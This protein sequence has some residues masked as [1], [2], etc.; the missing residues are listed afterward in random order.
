MQG[1]DV[2]TKTLPWAL[3][4]LT[5]ICASTPGGGVVVFLDFDG[6]LSPIVERPETASIDD[7]TRKSLATLAKGATVAIVSGR[8]LDDVRQRVGLED[9]IYAGSHGF[10]I[11]GPTKKQFTYQ[12]GTDHLPQ[13]QKAEEI[14]SV[15]LSEI[16]GTILERKKFSIAV[17]Y[18]RTA[19]KDVD[20]VKDILNE[21]AVQFIGLRLT[22]GKKVLELQPDVDWH[23]G[24]AINYL[25]HEVLHIDPQHPSDYLYW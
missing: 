15:R 20:K 13:I 7:D 24:H 6:T 14:L 8:D 9:L 22:S 16:P 21:I 25:I 17:H 18:R 4:Q 19:R 3:D 10:D 5:E 23:K 12:I 1:E 11:A 2:L